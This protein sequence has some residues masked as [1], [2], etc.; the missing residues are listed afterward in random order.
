MSK[1]RVVLS[2]IKVAG[3]GEVLVPAPVA[4][5]GV[6]LWHFLQ[7]QKELPLNNSLLSTNSI[8]ISAWFCFIGY[9][10]I[11]LCFSTQKCW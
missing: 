6:I 5:L 8:L 3:G 1:T 4:L 7:F 11:C 10:L 9:L 2:Q